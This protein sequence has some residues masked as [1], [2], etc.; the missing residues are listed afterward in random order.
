MG[1]EISIGHVQSFAC[2]GKDSVGP[3]VESIRTDC[4]RHRNSQAGLVSEAPSHGFRQGTVGV[5]IL[6]F[7]DLPEILAGRQQIRI[8]YGL[9]S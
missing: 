4:C 5:V 2:S 7:G 9:H 8:A 6:E 1:I 3:E